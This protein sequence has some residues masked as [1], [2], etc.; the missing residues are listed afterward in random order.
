MHENQCN[1]EARTAD[2]EIPAHPVSAFNAEEDAKRAHRRRTALDS[3]GRFRIDDRGMLVRI[4]D[5][6]D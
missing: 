3:Q 2:E 5:A 6:R 4:G 1:H